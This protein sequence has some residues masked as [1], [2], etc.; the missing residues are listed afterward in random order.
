MNLSKTWTHPYLRHDTIC[1]VLFVF[2]RSKIG[3]KNLFV[4]LHSKIGENSGRRQQE[5]SL[6]K[7]TQVASST[8]A[9]R[10][11]SRSSRTK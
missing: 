1:F 3:A 11:S 8:S 4:F 10:L 6:R 7:H 9:A 2:L 5:F